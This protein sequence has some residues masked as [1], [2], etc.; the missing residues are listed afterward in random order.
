MPTPKTSVKIGTPLIST[1]QLHL[2]IADQSRRTLDAIS[3][4]IGKLELI[5][6]RITSCVY[7]LTVFLGLEG[8]FSDVDVWV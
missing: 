4:L 5:F 7:D 8:K 1:P 3:I 2:R 6:S